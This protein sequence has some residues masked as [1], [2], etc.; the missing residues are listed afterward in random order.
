MS[1][2]VVGWFFSLA[3]DPCLVWLALAL[4]SA[5]SISGSSSE[6]G[7]T[8]VLVCATDGVRLLFLTR[9]AACHLFA[10]TLNWHRSGSNGWMP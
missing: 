5:I 6:F 4:R 1:C 7:R 10:P 9:R 2:P 3:A 8:F